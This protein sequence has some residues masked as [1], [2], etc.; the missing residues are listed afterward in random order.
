MTKA[1]TPSQKD[2]R[3]KRPTNGG[4]FAAAKVQ[5]S[6]TGF[7]KPVKGL[8]K[9]RPF[10]KRKIDPVSA[11]VP[12][13]KQ[14]QTAKVRPRRCS[15]KNVSW[16]EQHHVLQKY[17]DAYLKTGKYNKLPTPP[18]PEEPVPSKT[19]IN[20]YANYISTHEKDTGNLLTVKEFIKVFNK[21]GGKARTLT[22]E[23]RQRVNKIMVR[24]D[25]RNFPMGRKEVLNLI[26]EVSG[27]SF[28][29]AENHFD[30]LIRNKLLSG[31]KRDGRVVSAQK[32]TTKR[33]QVTIQRQL[34]A[35]REKK[36]A[37]KAAALE[38][39]RKDKMDGI[40]EDIQKGEN[41]F[42]QLTVS[43]LRDI[44]RFYFAVR[45]TNMNGL[46]KMELVDLLTKEYHNMEQAA[47]GQEPAEE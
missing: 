46:R 21:T 19:V 34:K 31:L 38:V 16:S 20:R 22:I 27:K 15:V 43:R 14:K 3:L 11:V 6:I 2:C 17:V 36:K 9:G 47:A 12:V 44:L 25:A 4:E 13:S 1:L 42:G 18:P 41:H 24:R 30:Y 40:V 29:A 8:I 33:S 7:F 39:E 26:A 10:K 37:D 23:Q 5:G 35:S 45:P 32:T 28:K